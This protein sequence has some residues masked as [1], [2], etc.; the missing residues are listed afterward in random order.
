MSTEDLARLLTDYEAVRSRLLR[1]P[2]TAREETDA[3][4]AA[5]GELARAKGEMERRILAELWERGGEVEA[6]G[7]VYTASKEGLGRRGW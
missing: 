1:W 2:T 4:R 3:V 5:F 7:R 6:G